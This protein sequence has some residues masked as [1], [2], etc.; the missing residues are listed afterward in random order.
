MVLMPQKRLHI[1]KAIEDDLTENDIREYLGIS[2]LG[3]PCNRH[4]FYKFRWFN[5]SMIITPREK[6]LFNRGHQEELVLKN[7][8]EKVGVRI[9]SAQGL[10]RTCYDHIQGH[11]DFIVINIPDAPKTYHLLECKTSALKY[12]E[13][14][15]KAQSVKKAFLSHFCQCQGYMHKF[16]LVRCLYVC[17]CKDDDR[18]YYERID[19]DKNFSLSL[20]E[21]G[22]AIVASK[23]YPEKISEDPKYYRC[24]EKWCEFR[25]VCHFKAPI[26]N[27]TCRSCKNV[28]IHDKGR[29]FC[30]KYE[31]FLTFEEQ[32][33]GCKSWCLL[34]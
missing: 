19:Y 18:R 30:N 7:D 23:V 12:F 17:T 6:R 31:K 22:E 14:L 11:Y 5:K 27:Q 32:I 34:R 26:E 9:V 3:H 8:L 21:K 33:K 16:K 2:Q 4:L 29:W 15:L 28:E 1:E 20:F 24:G 10:V 13:Q 25:M